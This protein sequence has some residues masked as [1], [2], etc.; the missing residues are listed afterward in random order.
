PALPRFQINS[1]APAMVFILGNLGSDDPHKQTPVLAQ[2]LVQFPGSIEALLAMARNQVRLGNYEAA[3]ESLVQV[4]G[5]DAFDWRVIWYRGL[6]LIAQQAPAEAVYAF[7]AGSSP[8]AGELA[9]H[10][11]VS[12]AA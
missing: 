9:A 10:P 6:A 7:G 5:L 12:I 8:V 1:T 11:A 3:E 2:A 4:E